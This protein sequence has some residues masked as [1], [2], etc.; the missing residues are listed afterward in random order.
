MNLAQWSRRFG[1]LVAPTHVTGFTTRMSVFPVKSTVP[2]RSNY[3]ETIHSCGFVCSTFYPVHSER[4]RLERE[5]RASPSKDERGS[6]GRRRTGRGRDPR[7]GW[8]SRFAQ[9]KQR[10][11]AGLPVVADRR[12]FEKALK[13]KAWSFSVLNSRSGYSIKR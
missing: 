13:A 10:I 2:E 11:E 5:R 1:S 8:L 12:R 3:L 4:G 7:C 6:D 9:A